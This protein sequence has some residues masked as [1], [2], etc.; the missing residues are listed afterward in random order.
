VVITARYTGRVRERGK[1]EMIKKTVHSEH[2]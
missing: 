1:A 2:T